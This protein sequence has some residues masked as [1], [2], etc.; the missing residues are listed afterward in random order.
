MKEKESPSD[1]PDP[2][3]QTNAQTAQGDWT[4]G[5]LHRTQASGYIQQLPLRLPPTHNRQR[6]FLETFNQHGRVRVIRE[7]ENVFF[8]GGSRW[9]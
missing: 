1:G 2:P 7:T 8:H 3:A 4:I 6:S 5:D 9:A